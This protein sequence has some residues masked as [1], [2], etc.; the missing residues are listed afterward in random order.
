LATLDISGFES[1][2]PSA[3]TPAFWRFVD[4]SRSPEDAEW[5]TR[6]TGSDPRQQSPLAQLSRSGAG[7]RDYLRDRRNRRKNYR[8][9]ST[10]A[11]MS[12]AKRQQRRAFGL[13]RANVKPY[14]RSENFPCVT[15]L[16]GRND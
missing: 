14:T 6:S 10:N 1:E 12:R 16:R 9:A 7:L 13:S 11:D 2:G 4:S 15:S 5:Q 8:T 3:K